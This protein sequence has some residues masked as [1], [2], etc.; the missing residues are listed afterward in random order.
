MLILRTTLAAAL[1]A[2]TFGIAGCGAEFSMPETGKGAQKPCIVGHGGGGRMMVSRERCA[3][4][5]ASDAS[6]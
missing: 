2:A 5:T 6:G 3:I 4:R 1:A